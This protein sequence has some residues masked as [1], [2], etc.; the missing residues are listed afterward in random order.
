MVSYIVPNGQT[1]HNRDRS[2]DTSE[3]RREPMLT[4]CAD[5][6]AEPSNML[7]SQRI[8]LR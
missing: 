3:T 7:V 8:M 6:A 5:N 4:V 2:E 1:Q